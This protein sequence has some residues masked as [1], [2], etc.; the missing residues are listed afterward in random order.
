[1]SSV[2]TDL[3]RPVTEEDRTKL[4]RYSYSK[5]EVFK[6][7]PYQYQMKYVQGKMAVDTSLAMELGSLLHKALEEKGKMK[8]ASS[9]VDYSMLAE[10]IQDG[11][12]ETDEKT[13]A[14]LPGIVALQY[15]YWETWGV[16]DSEGA[17]YDQ[18]MKVFD[19]VL[20]EEM[21][22]Q[23]WTPLKFEMPFEFVYKDRAI[24]HGFIDRVDFRETE[25]GVEYRTIDYK[26]SKKIYDSSKLTT[27]LQFGIYALAIFNA[28]HEVPIV[29]E[30]H[31]ILLDQI[32]QALTK[33]W[34]NRLIKA[35][36]GLL[37]KIDA[38]TEKGLWKACPTP[39]CHWCPFC[40]TNADATEYRNECEYYSLWTPTNK[41]FEVNKKYDEAEALNPK[42]A[43]KLIF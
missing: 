1:M 14:E 30:Y 39:L 6:N 38:N 22:D 34:E 11:V 12:V 17:T 15:K 42:P 32:Q 26:T 18:K 4:P 28:L 31:F 9:L 37:D 2:F 24:L 10:I 23:E 43:K 41:T 3:V 21:E 20:H 7:C 36:D 27:S 40:K 16:P 5:L 33:G 29:S 13:R 35:L 25:N 8:V 19:K